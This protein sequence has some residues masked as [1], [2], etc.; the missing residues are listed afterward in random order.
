MF[1]GHLAVALAA[2][3]AAPSA[4]LGWLMAGVTALD[5]IWPVLV[6]AGVEHVRIVPGATAFTPLVFD[7]Y[8]WSHSLVMAVGWG[9]VFAALGRA[10][11]LPA[12]ATLLI[13][14]VVSHWVLDFAS[15]APDMPL[16]PGSSPRFGLGLWDSIPLTLAIEG[17]MWAAAIAVY[18][19]ID[20]ARLT[21]AG[22]AAFWSMVVISTVMWASGPWSPPPPSERALGWFALIGWLL[23]PWAA[24]ADRRRGVVLQ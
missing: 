17:A 24:L 15:H 19:R 2:K 5:L 21:T 10:R 18:L 14:L 8:P 6:L 1:V 13:G 9:I 16:W 22:R 12:P 20:G 3:R 7:S 4:N 11:R 23:V